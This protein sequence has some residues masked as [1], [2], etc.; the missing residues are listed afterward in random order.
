MM[1]SAVLH[2]F[3][4]AVPTAP[5]ASSSTR[6]AWTSGRAATDE[7][8][9]DLMNS[10]VDLDVT[11]LK[12]PHHGSKTSSWEKFLEKTNPELTFISCGK[13]NFF[14]FPGIGYVSFFK[15]RNIPMFRTD[16]SGTITLITDGYTYQTDK[17]PGDYLTGSELKATK[18]KE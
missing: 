11:L 6:A 13:D 16:E 17:A 2:I 9:A 1:E 18:S 14:G 3:A 12:A 5:A 15:E 7:A 4:K 8:E 10:G